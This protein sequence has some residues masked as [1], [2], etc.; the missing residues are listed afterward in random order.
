MWWG[1]HMYLADDTDK[2]IY[3]C[4]WNKSL[5]SGEELLVTGLIHLFKGP[6]HKGKCKLLVV[7][8]RKWVLF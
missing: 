7:R 8:N 1:F 6:C 2:W 4:H 5:E 3:W